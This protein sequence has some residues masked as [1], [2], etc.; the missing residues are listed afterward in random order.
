[1]RVR[2]VAL[3]LNVVADAV[4]LLDLLDLLFQI[5]LVD[6]EIYRSLEQHDLIVDRSLYALMLL[7][8]PDEL[9]HILLNLRVITAC[10]R[11]GGDTH[12]NDCTQQ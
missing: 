7:F 11:L 6:V 5:H 8:A 2:N 10:R 9:V 1:M 12:G 4:N 3:D